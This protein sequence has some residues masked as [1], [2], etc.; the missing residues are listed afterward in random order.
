METFSEK[1]QAV[2]IPVKILDGKWMKWKQSVKQF[3]VGKLRKN[4]NTENWPE[5]F[6]VLKSMQKIGRSKKILDQKVSLKNFRSETWGEKFKS[7]NG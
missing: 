6:Y 5:E 3:Y 1:I 4:S 2:K 7:E